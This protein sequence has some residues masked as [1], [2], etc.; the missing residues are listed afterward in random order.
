MIQFYSDSNENI[1][2]LTLKRVDSDL[3]AQQQSILDLLFLDALHAEAGERNGH[4]VCGYL[5]GAHALEKI[6]QLC[7]QSFLY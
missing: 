1:K 5:E 3:L 2:R 4:R 6:S 7:I